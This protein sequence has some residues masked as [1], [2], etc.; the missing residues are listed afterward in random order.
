[1]NSY[2]L[3]KKYI[4]K[5]PIPFNSIIRNGDKGDYFDGT[6]LEKPEK[7]TPMD[8]EL[9]IQADRVMYSLNKTISVLNVLAHLPFILQ[10][11][12]ELIVESFIPEERDFIALIFSLYNQS[13]STDQNVLESQCTFMYESINNIKKG[14]MTKQ[15]CDDIDCDPNLTQIVHLLFN[16]KCIRNAISKARHPETI[17]FITQFIKDFEELK[18]VAEVKLYVTG[19]EE[20]ARDK[21]LRQAFKSN[22][23]LT[24]AI[25]DLKQQLEIQRKELGD[26][27]NQKVDTFKMYNEK[28]AKLKEEFQIS[29]EKDIHESEKRMMHQCLESEER[30]VVLAEEAQNIAKEYDTLLESHLEAEKILRAKRLKTETQLQTWLTKYDQDIGDKNSEYEGLKKEYD[31]EKEAMDDLEDKLED[32]EILY[33]RLMREKGEEEQ[34]IYLEIAFKIL[35]NRSARIIQRAWRA[36][37]ARKLAKRKGKKGK[38]GK[39]AKHQKPK[40]TVTRKED[41]NAALEG[42]FKGKV[43]EEMENPNAF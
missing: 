32:Q 21:R 42:K 20:E 2:A 7:L 26:E 18:E 31:E 34:R 19:T 28:I 14:K 9:R 40:L 41:P 8:M 22:I 38:K 36:Y 33:N 35:M 12:G 37:R 30:Q 16:N 11:K 39:D 5:P 27:L 3:L 6:I 43:F 17:P 24:A 15:A 1:M 23:M 10:N 13:M 29:I 25:R 4:K